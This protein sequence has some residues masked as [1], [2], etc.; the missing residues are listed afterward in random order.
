MLKLIT[1][2]PALGCRS[3]SPF[4][5]KAEALLTMSKLPFEKIYGD[6][7]KAPRGKFPVLMDGD[8]IIPDTAHIQAYLEEQKGVDFDKGL[9]LHQKSIAQAFRRLVED[10]LYFLNMYFRWIGARRTV[11]VM[12]FFRKSPHCCKGWFSIGCRKVYA[13]PFTCRGCPAT[14]ATRWLI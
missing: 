2:E 12:H 7:R 10:H 5:V 1:F 3:P 8:K 9:N 11:S 4:A 6:V 13:K 14:P